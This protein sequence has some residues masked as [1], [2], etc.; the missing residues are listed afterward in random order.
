[1]LGH[2]QANKKGRYGGTSAA[3]VTL[4]LWKVWQEQLPA[5]QRFAEG[6]P[7]GWGAQTWHPHPTP[8]GKAFSED[9]ENPTGI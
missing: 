3:G 1:M 2:P 8:D 6:P 5:Q 4:G 9:L 7:W